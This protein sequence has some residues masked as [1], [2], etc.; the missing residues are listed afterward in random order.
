MPDKSSAGTYSHTKP[1]SRGATTRLGPLA[2]IP[3]VLRSLGF[4][5]QDILPALGYELTFFDDPELPVP[6]VAAGALLARCVELTGCRHLGLRVGEG[7]GPSVLGLAGFVLMNAPDVDTALLDLVRF[8]D[9]HDRGGVP[10]LQT[11]GDT[12]LLGFMV[13]EPGVHAVDQINDLSIAVA[14]NIMRSLCSP[15]WNPTEVLLAH[16][17]PP[18]TRPWRAFFRSPVRFDAGQ[19]ALAFPTTWLRAPVAAANPALHRLL[20]RQAAASRSQAGADFVA[21][22]QRIV[23]GSI[24][25]GACTSKRV[26]AMLGLHERTLNRRLQG[27][28]TT[29]MKLR[30]AALYSKSRQ[31][32]DLSAMNL[33]EVAEAL[34]YADATTFIRAFNRWSGQTP[35]QWRRVQLHSQLVQCFV[36]FRT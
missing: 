19:C 17:P 22:V 27:E 28:G 15:S 24:A 3:E 2:R 1:S 31:L 34:G 4:A 10:T 20:E 21:E 12:S 33:A 32:L 35:A 11:V 18:D 6:Y 5:P 29:F 23:H 30:E 25:H 14:C 7:A 13:V 9:L 36:L 8:L 26:S 16:R